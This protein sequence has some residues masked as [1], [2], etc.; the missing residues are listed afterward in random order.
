M[1]VSVSALEVQ[2]AGLACMVA[3]VA[4]AVALPVLATGMVAVVYRDFAV[5]AVEHAAHEADIGSAVGTDSAEDLA[6]AD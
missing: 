6:V 2:P 3:V 1:E 5:A 4:A